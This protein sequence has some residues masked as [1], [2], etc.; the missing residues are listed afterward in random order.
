MR[1]SP[2]FFFNL[3]FDR[4]I[5][6]YDDIVRIIEIASAENVHSLNP[7]C[8]HSCNDALF[9]SCVTVRKTAEKEK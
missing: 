4:N 7:V 5:D 9:L 8:I 3:K 2:G 1:R 6:L